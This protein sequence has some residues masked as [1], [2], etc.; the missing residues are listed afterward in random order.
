ML[1]SCVPRFSINAITVE[2][3]RRT[4]YQIKKDSH[5]KDSKPTTNNTL[6]TI[7]VISE[8]KKAYNKNPT[9]SLFYMAIPFSNVEPLE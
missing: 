6:W 8:N 9:D 5:I 4:T 3:I 1:V 7:M 2:V